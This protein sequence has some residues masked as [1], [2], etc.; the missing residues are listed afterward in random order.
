VL[1][2]QVLVLVGAQAVGVDRG[3]VPGEVEVHQ[4]RGEAGGGP[5]RSEVLPGRGS[6]A[7]LLLELATGGQVRVLER[8]IRGAVQR[9]GRD[10]QECPAGGEAELPD[11]EDPPLGVKG[12]DRD[13]PGVAHDV[14]GGASPVG[15]EDVVDADVQVMALVDVPGADDD[16]PE[17]LVR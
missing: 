17:S 2:L 14:P 16:L 4:L 3:K 9:P 15:R 13:R 1:E 12:H 11:H 10:L 7:R 8:P 6:E 5:E